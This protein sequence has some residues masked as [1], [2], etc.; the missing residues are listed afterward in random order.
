VPF[1]GF[2]SNSGIELM[3]RTVT[4][5]PAVAEAA[6]RCGIAIESHSR[7]LRLQV[8]GRF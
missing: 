4:G 8:Y 3:L 6:E 5:S 1:S 2:R 7:S